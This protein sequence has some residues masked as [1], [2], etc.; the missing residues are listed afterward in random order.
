MKKFL[1]HSL[2]LFAYF[3][4]TAFLTYPVILKIGK[5]LVGARPAMYEYLWNMWWAKKVLKDPKLSLFST[6]YI[7]YPY[8][9]HLGYQMWE[10][11][12]NT[13]VS[14]P[15]QQIFSIATIQ[16]LLFLFTFVMSGYG[17]YLLSLHHTNHKLASFLS[18][19]TFAFCAYRMGHGLGH[20]NLISTQW[21]PFFILFLLKINTTNSKN[22]WKN[23]ILAGVFLGM[24]ALCSVYYLLG[25]LLFLLIYVIFELVYQMKSSNMS[26]QLKELLIAYVLMFFFFFLT[27]FPFF[28]PIIKEKYSG[29]EYVDLGIYGAADVISF[30]IPS[31]LHPVFKHLAKKSPVYIP[32]VLSVYIGTIPLVFSL[33]LAFKLKDLNHK[34]K[35]KLWMWS[36]LFFALM[37]LGP[38][39][40]IMGK[41]YPNILLP[42]W[43]L[44]R[45]PLLKDIRNPNR[46]AIFLMLSLSVLVGYAS[47]RIFMKTSAHP[48][49]FPLTLILF[50]LILTGILAEN[51]SIPYP[52][53][54]NEIPEVYL[55]IAQEKDSFAIAELNGKWSEEK[56]FAIFPKYMYY[57]TVHQK[58]L[59]GAR[60][61]RMNKQTELANQILKELNELVAKV[62]NSC[63][64]SQQYYQ[65]IKKLTKNYSIKYIILHE[66]FLHYNRERLI[67]S[68]PFRL[69]Y[70]SKDMLVFKTDQKETYEKI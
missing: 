38:Y 53:T 52:T 37:T 32:P 21:I 59:I 22:R 56:H 64:S 50:I 27:I 31:T 4:L 1:E 67:K 68:L 39:L 3:L 62:Y 26:F 44:K 11:A 49:S 70:E 66:E 28:I 57:Q 29:Y 24:C 12:F 51:I 43:V 16:G 46:F 5:H 13:L 69:I 10:S 60:T 18:G 30:F 58:K 14:I 63:A 47:L 54:P 23:S 55:E 34:I 45:I 25:S 65:K 20:L 17:V 42:F 15:L 33:I 36:G 8:E 48:K 40:K 19:A 6:D 35:I 61:A 2:V 7:G 41:E 9:I